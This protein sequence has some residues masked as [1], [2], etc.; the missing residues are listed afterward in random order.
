MT[1]AFFQ[2]NVE[3]MNARENRVGIDQ[4]RVWHFHLLLLVQLCTIVLSV[5]YLYL[6][7]EEAG[8][9]IQSSLV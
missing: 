1:F 8:T 9:Y 5:Q 6:V 7:T 4:V 2:V 3:C